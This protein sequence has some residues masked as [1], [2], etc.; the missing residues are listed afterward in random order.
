MAKNA[1]PEQYPVVRTIQ[2]SHAGY[3]RA[4]AGGEEIVREYW[5]DRVS[6]NRHSQRSA[7]VSFVVITQHDSIDAKKES[8]QR[9]TSK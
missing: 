6:I 9:M 4:I 2:L 5:V 7:R 1:L 8:W 3:Y